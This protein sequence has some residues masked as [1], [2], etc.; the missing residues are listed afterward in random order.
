MI[1][2]DT[3][4]I[5]A[6]LYP[7]FLVLFPGFVLSIY[8][9][10]DLEKYHHYFTATITVGLFT[11]MLS[12]LGRDKGK[13]K[14]SFLYTFW[15]GKPTT[16]ILRH[17]NEFLDKV[18]KARYHKLLSQKIDDIHI[19]TYDEETRSPDIADQTYDSCAK[20]LISKTRDT[21]KHYLLFKE[22][23]SYGFRR[24]LWGMKS[25]ALIII[26]F[27][28]IFHMY[29]ATNCFTTLSISS[30]SDIIIVAFLLF[31][32]YFWILIVTKD[33]IKL[34]AFAYAERLYETLNEL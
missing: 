2:L 29:W 23:V 27:C 9:I 19:P 28:F 31:L 24:N 16:Q 4:N 22:N 5:K 20:F 18:T 14:E 33:W 8:Y 12:Q 17:N 1:Q 21:K 10:T 25:W 6:R 11:F 34:I 15:G 13:S 26:A 7:S 32:T 3:Y 30:K